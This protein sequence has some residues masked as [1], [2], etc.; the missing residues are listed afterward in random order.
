MPNVCSCCQNEFTDDVELFPKLIV[1]RDE[2]VAREL[3]DDK[4]EV[5][6]CMRGAPNG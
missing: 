6:L 1:T 2:R 5:L 3:M 4:D